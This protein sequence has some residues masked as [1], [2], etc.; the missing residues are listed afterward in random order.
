MRRFV[1]STLAVLLVLAALSCSDTPDEE[2]VVGST[3]LQGIV[4]NLTRTTVPVYNLIPPEVCPSHYDLRPSDVE[5]VAS[6][7]VLLLQP[8]QRELAGIQRVIEAA[9]TDPERVKVVPVEGNW[10]TPPVYTE[11][12]RATARALA[13][14]YP[15]QQ[16]QI[17]RLAEELIVRESEFAEGIR[18]RLHEAGVAR[19]K[20]LCSEQQAQFV[21]WAGFDIAEAFGRPEDLSVAQIEEIMARGREAGA[22]LVVDNIQSG[23]T[24][25]GAN[26]AAGIGAEHV[27]LSNFPGALPDAD[28]WERTVRKNVDTLMGGVER[29]QARHG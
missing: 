17:E 13:G 5:R 28:S 29:W 24:K 21:Q 19:I 27:V 16:Q 25:M 6:C 14:E 10:M 9:Q 12:I 26:L 2:V 22:M 15:E 7:R 8:W 1:S 3:V 23:D 20:V 4:Q 18:E 11:A